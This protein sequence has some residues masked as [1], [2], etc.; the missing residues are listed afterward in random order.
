VI[1]R[2]REREEKRMKDMTENGHEPHTIIR[3]DKR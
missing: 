2:K 3:K 1:E